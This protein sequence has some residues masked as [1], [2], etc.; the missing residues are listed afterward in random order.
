MFVAWFLAETISGDIPQAVLYG[1]ISALCGALVY[2][3]KTAYMAVQAERDRIRDERDRLRVDE[4]AGITA[5]MNRMNEVATERNQQ[6]ADQ[7]AMLQ[8][9]VRN[10]GAINRKLGLGNGGGGR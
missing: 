4:L 6:V 5:I 8:Q 9:L 7:H 3:A 10:V 1:A 2:V